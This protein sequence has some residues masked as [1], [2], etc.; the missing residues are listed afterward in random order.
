MMS[1]LTKVKDACMRS[2]LET[3]LEYMGKCKYA[4]NVKITL[5]ITNLESSN[6]G[7]LISF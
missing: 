4:L 5:K 6:A 1:D 7:I 2:A 3:A